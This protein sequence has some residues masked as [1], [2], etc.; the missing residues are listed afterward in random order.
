MKVGG[1]KFGSWK[2][3]EIFEPLKFLDPSCR[4]GDKAKPY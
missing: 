1:W 2:I 4:R 3:G